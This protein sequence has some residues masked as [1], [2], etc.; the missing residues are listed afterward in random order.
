MQHASDD[1]ERRSPKGDGAM[2][3]AEIAAELGVSRQRALAILNS[4]LAKLRT[5]LAAKGIKCC[6]DAVPRDKP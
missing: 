5:K 3:L 1:I 2:T 4:G 6:D